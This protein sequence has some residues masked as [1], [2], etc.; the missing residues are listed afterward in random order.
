MRVVDAIERSPFWLFGR[1]FIPGRIRR[2]ACI[3]REEH[4]LELV[5][6]GRNK[7]CFRCGTG[8]T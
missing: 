6:V 1:I 3:A 7:V 4:H 5:D 8:L 2:R